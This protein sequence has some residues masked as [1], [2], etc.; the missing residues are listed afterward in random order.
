MPAELRHWRAFVAAAETQHFGAAAERLGISQSALSQLIQALEASL[1]TQLFDRAGR[2]ARLTEPGRVVLPEARAA[3]S[4]AFRAERIGAAL[5]RQNARTLAA[6]YVGSAVFHQSFATLIGTIGAARPSISLRLDQCSATNQVRYLSEQSLDFGIVRSPLP[7]LDPSLAC[8]TLARDHMVVALPA[9]HPKAAKARCSL[10]LF[11]DEPLIQYIE[12]PSGGL[13]ALA[14]NA[15]RMA[16]FEPKIAQTVPQIA[17]ML[18]LVGAGV[19]VALV[20]ETMSRLG[21]P[22]IVYRAISEPV[23]TELTLLYRRSDTAPAI[24]VLIRLA[25]RLIDKPSLSKPVF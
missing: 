12:Q 17:T 16:G 5:G 9:A 4:Q 10:S 14:T 1:G 2:R 8:M 21:V 15:C 18:C 11:A 20:P 6:G 13:R 7:N 19:G 3:L 25:R 22:G 24:R 23:V